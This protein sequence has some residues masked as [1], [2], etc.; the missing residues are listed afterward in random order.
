MSNGWIDYSSDLK[1]DFN[2][3]EFPFKIFFFDWLGDEI[4]K[5]GKSFLNGLLIL[6]SLFG[7]FKRS[8]FIWVLWKKSDYINKSIKWQNE[9]EKNTLSF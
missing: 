7:F 6:I 9:K 3:N 4:L 1:N 2:W 5:R 8:K